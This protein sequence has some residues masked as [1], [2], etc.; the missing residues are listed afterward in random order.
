MFD[1]KAYLTPAKMTASGQL[2][3]VT[4]DDGTVLVSGKRDPEYSAAR[5]M[6]EMG[7]SGSVAFFRVTSP[8]PSLIFRDLAKAAGCRVEEGKLVG[9]RTRKWR[10]MDLPSSD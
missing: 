1:H 8:H 6:A 10:P 9:P 7:L 3:D 5:A 4:L 2:Y